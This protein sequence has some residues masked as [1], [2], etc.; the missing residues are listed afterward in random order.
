M[1]AL[2]RARAVAWHDD[3]ATEDDV[4]EGVVGGDEALCPGE[5][6]G[7]CRAVTE[8]RVAIL[9]GDVGVH[10]LVGKQQLRH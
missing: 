2:K 9:V 1:A 4:K 6:G 7:A 10:A 8:Y 5:E 3:A